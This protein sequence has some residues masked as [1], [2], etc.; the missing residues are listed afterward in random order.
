VTDDPLVAAWYYL[1]LA[2]LG[3]IVGSFL[4]V[5]IYRVP[6]GLSIVRPPSACP[7]CHTPIAPRDNIPVVSWLL[8][9]GR[10][11]TCHEAISARYPLVEALTGVVW[12]LLGWWC[13]GAEGLDPL[14]PLLLVLGSAGV[15]LW[16]IDLDHHRLPDAIVLPLYPVTLVG[17]VVAGVV[18][19]SW[20]LSSTVIGLAAWALLIGG[21]WLFS[22]GRAMGFGDVKLA[23]VLGATLGWV[24]VSSALVGLLCAFVLGGVIGVVLLVTGR[25]R[26]GSHMPFGPFLLLGALVGLVAGEAIGSA[27]LGAVGL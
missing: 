24:G 4:N 26:R 27:Y 19:G 5:V 23:P 16:F 14:L 21:L 7:G 18:S 2:G 10:C 17:L 3:V 12:L 6:L 9:R 25:A 1:L 8:L 11:R 22:G 15:A 20:P 13:W